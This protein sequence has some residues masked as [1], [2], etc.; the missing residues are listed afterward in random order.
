MNKVFFTCA[1]YVFDK[2]SELSTV[3]KFREQEQWSNNNFPDL[4]GLSEFSGARSCQFEYLPICPFQGSNK[5]G[6]FSK[7]LADLKSP[8]TA[9][10]TF[11]IL[12]FAG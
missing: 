10:F 11:Q 9:Y 12:N 7:S 2:V 8:V 3:E 6:P 1:R 5:I 4:L